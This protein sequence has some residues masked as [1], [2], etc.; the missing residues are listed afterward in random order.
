MYHSE[1]QLQRGAGGARIYRS[2]CNKHQIVR[3]SKDFNFL[4][5]QSDS[6]TLWTVAC[7][8]PLSMGF[9]RPEYW[10]GSLSL[11]QRIFPTQGLKPRVPH[12][13]RIL[14]Q[15]SHTGSPRTLKWVA[16]PFSSGSFPPRNRTRVSCIAGRFFTK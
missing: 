14:Y 16:Y 8:A 12:Y 2:F 3:T 6:A 11:L 9:S 7:Q 15:L 1:R 5:A 10:V 4:V 13:R